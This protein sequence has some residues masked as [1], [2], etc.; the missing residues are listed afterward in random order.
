MSLENFLYPM[1]VF[2]C[3]LIAAKI[4]QQ[5]H[6]GREKLLSGELKPIAVRSKV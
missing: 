4:C 1:A 6:Q 3:V 5:D 2:E